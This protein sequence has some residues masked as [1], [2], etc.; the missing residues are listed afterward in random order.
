MANSFYLPGRKAIHTILTHRP[1]ALLSIFSTHS[2]SLN[3]L[4]EAC[5]QQGIPIQNCTKDTLDKLAEGSNHQ[6]IVA[7]IRPRAELGEKALKQHLENDASH[8]LWLILERIQNPGN[9]GAVLRNA[10]ATS[11]D[12][13]ILSQHDSAPFTP[14]VR[15][16]ACGASELLSV[17]RVKNIRR[18]I[19]HL[20]QANIWTYALDGHAQQSLYACDFSN[21][22]TAIVL[23]S[24]GEGLK[25]STRT[26]CD[27]TVSLPLSDKVESLNVASAC[28]AAL[29]EILRQKIA[30]HPTH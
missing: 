2:D 23:G 15:K 30:A 4:L 27:H 21:Q 26:L 8:S 9:L 18:S 28:S 12:G 11:V 16:S 10:C 19:Q 17:Y 5:Q 1:Q 29:Y 25:Q 22:A 6:G 13:V 3:P 24:E 20:Q 7:A 14:V